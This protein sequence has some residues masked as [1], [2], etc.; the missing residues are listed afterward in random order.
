M[1]TPSTSSVI[2]RKLNEY[3][4]NNE[5]PVW[6]IPGIMGLITKEDEELTRSLDRPVVGFQ[7]KAYT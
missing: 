1:P 4:G 6:F 5:I 2:A 7:N 3:R